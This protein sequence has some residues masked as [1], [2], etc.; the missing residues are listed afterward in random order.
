MHSANFTRFNKGTGANPR[1][2]VELSH[3]TWL[4]TG[5]RNICLDALGADFIEVHDFSIRGDNVAPPEICIQFG[6]INGVSS[7][8]NKLTRANCGG[9]FTFTLLAL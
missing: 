6:V 8:W 3:M 2:R 5:A 7:A 4:C 9:Y 1:P